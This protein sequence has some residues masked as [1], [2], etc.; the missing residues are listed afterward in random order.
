[1]GRAINVHT[2]DEVARRIGENLE[3]IELVSANSDNFDYS[4]MIVTVRS[5]GSIWASELV[6]PFAPRSAMA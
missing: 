3:L 5:W 2:I 6:T 1:M 4:E